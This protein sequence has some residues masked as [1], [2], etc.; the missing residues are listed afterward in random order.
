MALAAILRKHMNR[1]AGDLVDLFVKR[2]EEG[3]FEDLGKLLQSLR[4]VGI[5]AAQAHLR[6]RDGARAPRAL[7]VR[8][9]D[10]AQTPPQEGQERLTARA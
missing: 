10:Q 4:P 6:S 2:T 8:Q 3:E 7:R 9:D 5:E 1:A